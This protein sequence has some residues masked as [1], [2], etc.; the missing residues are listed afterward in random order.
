MWHSFSD[1]PFR[2][3]SVFEI[4]VVE[5]FLSNAESQKKNIVSSK[6]SHA[7]QKG[8]GSHSDNLVVYAV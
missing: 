6:K 1:F 8:N 3:V 7:R 2:D 4:F 5:V